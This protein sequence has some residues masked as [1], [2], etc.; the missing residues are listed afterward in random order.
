M[1]MTLDIVEELKKEVKWHGRTPEEAAHY[2]EECEVGLGECDVMYLF[3]CGSYHLLIPGHWI[4]VH[5]FF[6]LCRMYLGYGETIAVSVSDVLRILRKQ[7][8]FLCYTVYIKFIEKT[9]GVSVC[10]CMN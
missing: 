1:R 7:L 5:F 4:R 6:C 10:H 9:V 8:Q 3:V 2:C